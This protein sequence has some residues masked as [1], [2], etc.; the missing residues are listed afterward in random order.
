[1]LVVAWVVGSHTCSYIPGHQH[2]SPCVTVSGWL[3]TQLCDHGHRP[4]SALW[5]LHCTLL[6]R[7]DITVT[8][9]NILSSCIVRIIMVIPGESKLTVLV[10]FTLESMWF[11][12]HFFGPWT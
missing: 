8:P 6:S 1:M 3:V 10:S 7:F 12:D 9:S 4:T 5:A 2:L 11:G